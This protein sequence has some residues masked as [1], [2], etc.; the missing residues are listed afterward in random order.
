MIKNL[1]YSLF[2]HFLLLLVIY[3]NFNL[4]KFDENKSTE[5]A[6][7]LIAINGSEDSNKTKPNS[8]AEEKKEQSLKPQTE[9]IKEPKSQKKSLKN[10]VKEQPKKLAKSKPVKSIKKPPSEE[11]NQEFKQEEKP[12]ERQE[13]A[14][15]IKDDKVIN[16]HLDEEQN[17]N[18]YKEK[19]LG[20]KQKFNQEKEA[21]NQNNPSKNEDDSASNVESVDLSAREKFNIQSQLKRCY[22]RA[23]DETKLNSKIRV[24]IKVQI[25]EDGYIDSDLDEMVD[26]K[27]YNDPKEPRYKIAI[28]NIGRALDLCSPLRNLPLDKYDVWKEAIL[29]FDEDE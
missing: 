17:D 11:K 3:A 20:S 18:L 2:L 21:S 1:L 12:E 15:K 8:D 5:I 13:E 24:L 9:T 29:E 25:S 26:M 16:E 10:K 6:V 7:S 23:L 19:D 28:D 27:R 22:K 4:K 14:N